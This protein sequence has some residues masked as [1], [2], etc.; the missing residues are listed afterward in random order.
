MGSETN[1]LFKLNN[2]GDTKGGV[3]MSYVNEWKMGGR[4]ETNGVYPW[5]E[6]K[7]LI[8]KLGVA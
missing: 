2:C 8:E 6:E 1:Q 3:W 7:K 4:V 5:N